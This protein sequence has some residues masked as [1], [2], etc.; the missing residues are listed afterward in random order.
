MHWQT[1]VRNAGTKGCYRVMARFER[2]GDD[3]NPH[4]ARFV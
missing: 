3:P 1:A 4:P 2:Q